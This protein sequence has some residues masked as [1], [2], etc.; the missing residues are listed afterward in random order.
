[1]DACRIDP[2][3][4]ECL[5]TFRMELFSQGSSLKDEVTGRDTATSHMVKPME[6][7]L[8]YDRLLSKA[9]LLTSSEHPDHSALDAACAQLK[10]AQS[11]IRTTIIVRENK[12]L[13]LDIE[14]SFVD[15]LPLTL[16]ATLLK[17]G[18]R[19]IRRGP[20]AKVCRR[21]DKEFYFWL[22]NDLL[23]YGHFV[24]NNKYKF[25][26]SFDLTQNC[27]ISN[28]TSH[29]SNEMVHPCFTISTKN[30]SFVVFV[31]HRPDDRS[32]YLK[33]TKEKGTGAG[34]LSE[35]KT[36]SFKSTILHDCARMTALELRDAWY[37]DIER[38]TAGRSSTG[39]QA[40]SGGGFVAPVWQTDKSSSGCQLCGRGFTLTRRRHHCRI[41]GRLVCHACSPHRLIIASIDAKKKM[42]VCNS[43]EKE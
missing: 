16:N 22:F 33:D 34:G 18:R 23:I 29:F 9:L 4:S 40:V 19:F 10:E 31:G 3:L 21:E 30:K 12:D 13:L 35:G 5:S 37:A 32:M 41:C 28:S 26:R 27:Q 25:H 38:L 15:I 43:C 17:K 39:D 8:V 14:R 36:M 11:H 20:L 6:R 7:M 42:R 24:G 1:M 2:M